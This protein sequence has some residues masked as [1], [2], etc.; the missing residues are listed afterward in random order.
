MSV[1]VPNSCHRF[2][3]GEYKTITEAKNKAKEERETAEREMAL[4][5]KAATTI[6]AVWR[7]YKV[8]KALKQKNKKGKKS[9]K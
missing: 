3:Q 7:S 6:Q 4:M 1:Y 5:V 9:K 2:F 8:R